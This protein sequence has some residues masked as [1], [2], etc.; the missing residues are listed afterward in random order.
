M[1]LEGDATLG[2]REFSPPDCLTHGLARGTCSLVAGS[3][4]N[5]FVSCA[6]HGVRRR[7]VTAGEL[8]R[9]LRKG[10]ATE[11]GGAP[12]LAPANNKAEGWVSLD[13]AAK[14]LGIPLRTLRQN[15]TRNSRAVGHVIEAEVD[16]IYARKTFRRWR[17]WLGPEWTRPKR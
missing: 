11:A 15:L 1:E 4:H 14:Q 2:R 6:Q 5:L 13:V 8:R 16:G 17:V 10:S 12:A 7:S 3:S 9:A